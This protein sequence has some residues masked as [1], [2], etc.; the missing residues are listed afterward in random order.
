MPTEALTFDLEA[1]R[2]AADTWGCNCGPAALAAVCGITLDAVRAYM[3]DF[4]SKGYTNPSLMAASL[5]RMSVPFKRTYECRGADEAVNPLY[6]DYGLVRIQWAGP[7]TTPGVPVK[8]RYHHTHWIGLRHVADG[9]AEA[10]DVNAMY[11][12]G[13]IPWLEWKFQL[14]PW[15]MKQVE[16]K[17]DGWWPTHCW[18]IPTHPSPLSPQPST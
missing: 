15:L 8:A 13:W 17:A 2:H 9:H 4:E 3:G 14:N 16:P 7:W 12:G 5:R 11:S 6:P 10:F 18:D 1:A